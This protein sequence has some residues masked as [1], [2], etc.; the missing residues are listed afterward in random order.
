[1]GR[2]LPRRAEWREERAAVTPPAVRPAVAAM[3]IS[4]TANTS[5]GA[6]AD[7]F[8]HILDNRTSTDRFFHLD[9]VIFLRPT[10]I[11]FVGERLVRNS[12]TSREVAPE[13]LT[14]L[15]VNKTMFDGG[16]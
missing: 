5:R 10:A 8:F 7:K 4:R 15:L 12:Y 11:F 9:A 16:Q 2:P 13:F 14:P 6:A 3:A 1:M